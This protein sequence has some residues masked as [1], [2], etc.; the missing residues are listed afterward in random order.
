M[1]DGRQ[2]VDGFEVGATGQLTGRWSVFSGYT[3]MDSEILESNTPAEVGQPVNNTPRH[4]FSLWTTVQLPGQFEVGGGAWYVADR[5]NNNSG[6]RTAPGYW[7]IDATAARP[8]GRHLTLR[9]KGSN[10]A[11]ESY[12]DRVGGGHFVPGPGRSVLLTADVGF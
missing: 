1:L 12:I 3:F 5:T 6:Q 4:S 8:I 2:K 7:V 11:D 9:L 10:L